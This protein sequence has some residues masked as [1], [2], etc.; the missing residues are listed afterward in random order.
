L[1]PALR[2]TFAEIVGALDADH[3]QVADTDL[4]CAYV[5]A[6][7]LE[8]AAREHLDSEGGV[9]GGK[10]NAWL[11]VLEKAQRA[12]TA[13]SLRLRIGPQART[14]ARVVAVRQNSYYDRVRTLE[15]DVD[16]REP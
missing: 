16:E 8:R 13:L 14:R 10:A 7:H 5:A 11:V 4:L 6:I 9:V 15:H 1:K 2:E 3:F 12:M